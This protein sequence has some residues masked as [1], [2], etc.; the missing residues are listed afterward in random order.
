MFK[1]K[2]QKNKN[3]LVAATLSLGLMTM[4]LVPMVSFFHISRLYGLMEKLAFF[5]LVATVFLSTIEIFSER[6]RG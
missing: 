2:I 1:L 4:V 6:K 5:I 3:Y